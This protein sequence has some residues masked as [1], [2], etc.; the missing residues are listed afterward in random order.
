MKKTTY[1]LAVLSLLLTAACGGNSKSAKIS[2]ESLEFETVTAEKRV[3]ITGESG[4]PT[5]DVQLQIAAVRM[6]AGEKAKVANEAII[7]RLLN[8][9]GLTVKQ[10]VDS[11]ANAYTHNYQKDFAPLYREDRSDPAKRAWYEYH[12]HITTDTQRGKDGV[13]VYT[14]L[15]DYY[16]G[17]A[18]GISQKLVFNID[19]NTGK[20]LTLT[21]IMGKEAKRELNDK[22]LKKLMEKTN[23]KSL[24]ELHDRGYLY[25]MDIFAPDNFV[26]GADKITF[27][28]NPYEIAPYDKGIIE[29]NVEY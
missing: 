28:Y 27:V 15:L 4:A 13:T 2:T 7:E 11:F 10:A 3:A 14:A 25:S 19:N 18:H 12:Y 20:V 29:L 23:A 17:G 24:D 16:E 1:T 5:C 21:D 26:A 22:L 8:M 6:D 9:E